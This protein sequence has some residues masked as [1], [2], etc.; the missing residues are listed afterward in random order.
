MSLAPS[1]GDNGSTAELWNV[2]ALARFISES[3]HAAGFPRLANA[4]KSTVWRILDDHDIKP[5]KIG[6][7]L[8]KRDPDFERKMQEVLMVYQDVSLYR[9]GAAHDARPHAIYTVIVDEKPGV[10]SIGLKAPD[11]PP[12]GSGQIRGASYEVAAAATSRTTPPFGGYHRLKLRMSCPF[13][14]ALRTCSNA[15]APSLVHRMCPLRFMR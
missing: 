6:Y 11:L 15:F 9:E 7:Y 10:Q 4:G 13:R 8:E 12:V 2:S 1:P 5:H 14:A 3:A